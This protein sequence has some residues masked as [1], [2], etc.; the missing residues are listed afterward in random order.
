MAQYDGFWSYGEC[1][2]VIDADTSPDVQ[3]EYGEANIRLDYTE[4]AAAN[5]V[6]MII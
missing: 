4:A 3:W 2:L 5:V 1:K 6:Q